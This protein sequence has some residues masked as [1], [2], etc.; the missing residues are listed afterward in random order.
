MVLDYVQ[1]RWANRYIVVVLK[2][3]GMSSFTI[4]REDDTRQM[5]TADCL[6]LLRKIFRSFFKESV[7]ISADV[8]T[9]QE[10]RDLRQYSEYI[11]AKH[12]V[13]EFFKN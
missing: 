6:Q 12:V 4:R 10:Q 2:Q 11:W 3:L 8:S 9:V 13:Q 7:N 5:A 1:H